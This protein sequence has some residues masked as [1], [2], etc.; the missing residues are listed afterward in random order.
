MKYT[1]LHCDT[2]TA[3]ENE[4]NFLK[5]SGHIDLAR[6]KAAEYLAVCFAVFCRSNTPDAAY[7]YLLEKADFFG[8]LLSLYSADIAAART[9]DDIAENHNADKLSAILTVENGS[10]IGQDLSRIYAVK[11]L[12]VRLITLTWS[13][14]NSL[15][16]PSS[17]IPRLHLKGLKAAGRAA[18]EIMNEESI[19]IDVSHL[20]EGGFWDV[21]ELSHKPFAATHSCCYS[22]HPHPRNLSDAQ[23]RRIGLCGGV[24]GICFYNEFINGGLRPTQAEDIAAQAEKIISLAGEDTPALGSDFDGMDCPLGFL[25]CEGI[26]AVA[27]ALNQKFS[28]RVVDKILFGNYLRLFDA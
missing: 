13:L 2:L 22:L 24:M 15:G 4:D 19:I 25:G 28:A 9:A 16:F 6:L 8:R 18:V 12:G 7:A 5:N 21:A 23:I 11:K 1:D 26:A 20:S 10:F 17:P 27:E 3:I 14:E